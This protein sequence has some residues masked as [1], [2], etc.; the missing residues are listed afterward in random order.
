MSQPASELLSEI[1]KINGEKRAVVGIDSRGRVDIFLYVQQ[2][3]K[4]YQVKLESIRP[5]LKGNYHGY[6]L[7]GVGD[8]LC[9]SDEIIES[10]MNFGWFVEKSE[11]FV[12]R[13]EKIYSRFGGL[14]AILAPEDSY[15]LFSSLPPDYPVYKQLKAKLPKNIDG[16]L[17]SDLDLHLSKQKLGSSTY[18]A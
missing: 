17:S 14:S 12:E 1:M 11:R 10:I 15:E 4:V 5:G 16:R 2:H 3:D 13:V 7:S 8:E 18:I 6:H 9:V